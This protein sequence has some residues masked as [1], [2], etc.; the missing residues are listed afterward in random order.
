MRS[1]Q[2]ILASGSPYRRELLQRLKL[3]FVVHAADIDERSFERHDRSP[4]DVASILA[5]EKARRVL[6]VYPESVV[7]GS[8][9][10]VSLNGAVLGK[11]GSE[12]AAIE[13][14]RRLSGRGHQLITAVAVI[15]QF[16]ES[17]FVNET[18]MRMRSLTEDEVIRYVRQDRPW[19][20]A[21]SYRIEALGIALFDAIECGDFTAI[22]G[23]P[24]LELASV[25]R[26]HG[27][28]IP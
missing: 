12:Q 20:C 18:S 5:A 24:L 26:R 7:I 3:D 15:S 28:Q 21:G 25:L 10:V 13:Q 8:D 19:D 23:L 16:R 17:S 9:Q 27:F 1:P 6:A 2:L 4:R 22:T 14:L 11:P